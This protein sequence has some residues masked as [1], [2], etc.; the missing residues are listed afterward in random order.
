[1][2]LIKMEKTPAAFRALSCLS[3]W[4]I[5][6]C[7]D[8]WLRI[9]LE[10]KSDLSSD[11]PLTGYSH[12]YWY[13]SLHRMKLTHLNWILFLNHHWLHKT[14]PVCTFFLRP[15]VGAIFRLLMWINVLCHFVPPTCWRRSLV[16]HLGII[17]WSWGVSDYVTHV[18][19]IK[20][21]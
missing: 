18:T 1:M 16:G 3:Q 4:N 9:D 13:K 10:F 17:R 8:D 11:Q 6:L 21:L 7:W 5:V 12:G 19:S 20:T 14:D 15:A 2:R